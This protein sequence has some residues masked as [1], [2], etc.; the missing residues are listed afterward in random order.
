LAEL[1]ARIVRDLA[2][3]L[4]EPTRLTGLRGSASAL[5]LARFHS[6]HPR[7]ILVLA[8]DAAAPRRSRPT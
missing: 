6:A 8:A 4:G 2:M 5:L 7:P 3:P 1:V